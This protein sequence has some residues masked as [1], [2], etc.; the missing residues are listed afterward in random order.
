MVEFTIGELVCFAAA[1]LAVGKWV[2]WK[3]EAQKHFHV[4]R[5]MIEEEDV[6]KKIVGDFEKWRKEHGASAR[7]NA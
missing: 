3:H 5:L 6:R 7:G 1:V 4:L 2:Y